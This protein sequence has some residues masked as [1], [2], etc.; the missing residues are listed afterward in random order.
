LAVDHAGPAVTEL[1][2]GAGFVVV[3]TAVVPDGIDTVATILRE[4]AA[5]F[6][7]LLVTTGGTGFAPRDL[8]PEATQ[9]VLEREAPGLEEAMRAA[10]PRGRLSRGRAG[11]FRTCLVVNVPGSTTGATECLAAIV[12]VL[13]HALV[14]LAGGKPHPRS[15]EAAP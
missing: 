9:A 14:L 1:L 11:T 3:D 10:S 6:T 15:S 4:L 2:A 12:D 7:G 5:D 13:P 8:T